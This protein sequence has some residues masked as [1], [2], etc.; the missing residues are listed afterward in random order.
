MAEKLKK[1][2]DLISELDSLDNEAWEEFI[3]RHE[4]EAYEKTNKEIDSSLDDTLKLRKEIEPFLKIIRLKLAGDSVTR[5]SRFSA[6]KKILI[7]TSALLSTTDL[8]GLCFIVATRS[9]TKPI[10]IPVQ[11]FGVPISNKIDNERDDDINAVV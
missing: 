3:L 11:V 1:I 4:V 10:D 9:A 2:T 7:E 8:V 6:V 5:I